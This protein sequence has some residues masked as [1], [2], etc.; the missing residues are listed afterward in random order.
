MLCELVLLLQRTRQ[1]GAAVSRH[2]AGRVATSCASEVEGNRPPSASPAAMIC[3]GVNPNHDTTY[4]VQDPTRTNQSRNVV[5]IR[6]QTA[7][8]V[9]R[10]CRAHTHRTGRVT[11]GVLMG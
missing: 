9:C 2:Q 6:M 1:G 4:D 5:S 11:R 10:S 3:A 8:R 7:P